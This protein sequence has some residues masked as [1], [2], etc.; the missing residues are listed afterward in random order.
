M[1]CNVL[2]IKC[3]GGA[4]GE[5]GNELLHIVD[6]CR[7]FS[8]TGNEVTVLGPRL[9]EHI[10]LAQPCLELRALYF[11]SHRNAPQTMETWGGGARNAMAAYMVFYTKTKFLEL[12]YRAPTFPHSG[13]GGPER[14]AA[15]L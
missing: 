7:I 8:T 6:R 5:G 13:F 4:R 15:L 12:G 14:R 3:V 1:A 2:T 9:Q 11:R 10:I